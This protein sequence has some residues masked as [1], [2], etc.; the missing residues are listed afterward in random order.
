MDWEQSTE[1]QFL[2]GANLP[3]QGFAVT[4]IAIR[5]EMMQRRDGNGQEQC[6]IGTLEGMAQ[7]W[8]INKTNRKFLREDAGISNANVSA[9]APIPLL[10]VQNHTSMGT[11]ILAQLR[12]VAAPAPVAAVAPVAVAPVA[13]V[14]IVQPANVPASA[15]EVPF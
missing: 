5:T 14:P 9:F 11:G 4:L 3:P 1:G 2:A 8:V 7:E 15:D 13:A 12:A 10:F 6:F